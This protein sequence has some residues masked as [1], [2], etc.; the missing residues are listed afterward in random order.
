MFNI[1]IVHS[2]IILNN[3]GSIVINSF[4]RPDKIATLDKAKI[5]RELGV[6]TE[7]KLNEV[8]EK[9]KIILEIN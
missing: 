1:I 3:V 2:F 8:K 7:A 6:I 9:L 4:I 5:K